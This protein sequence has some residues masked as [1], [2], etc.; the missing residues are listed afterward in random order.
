MDRM[1]ECPICYKEAGYKCKF[2]LIQEHLKNKHNIFLTS[3]D[4]KLICEKRG[5]I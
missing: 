1:V 4:I 2:K 3:E 5:L